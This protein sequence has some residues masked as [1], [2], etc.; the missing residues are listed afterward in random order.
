MEDAVVECV[1]QTVC[2][3]DDQ[4]KLLVHQDLLWLHL[5]NTNTKHSSTFGRSAAT[6]ACSTCEGFLA[7]KKL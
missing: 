5:S 4:F 2:E 6:F 3:A 1:W 7:Q